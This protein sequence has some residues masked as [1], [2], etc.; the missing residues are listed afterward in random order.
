MSVDD[1]IIRIQA[2]WQ[3]LARLGTLPSVEERIR[4]ASGVYLSRSERASLAALRDHGSLRISELAH[5]VGLDVSTM[6]RTL[7]R[8]ADAGLIDRRPGADLRAV[9]ISLTPAGAEALAKLRQAGQEMLAEVL[10]EWPEGERA[11]LASLMSRFAEMF[12]EYLTAPASECSAEEA[13]S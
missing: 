11:Q 8:L 1:S 3:Q 10:A 7:P 4:H 6:S 2:A 5:L 12:G 9:R 13:L